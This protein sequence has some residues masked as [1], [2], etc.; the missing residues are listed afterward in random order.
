[1][2][3]IALLWAALLCTQANAADFDLARAARAC[4]AGE[5]KP[6][7]DPRISAAI[8]L[9]QEQHH[10]FGGQVIDRRGGIVR[11]GFHEAEFD[12]LKTEST[13]TWQRVAQFWASLEEDLPSTFRSP[14]GNMV[15]RRLM[16][17]RM[18]GLGGSNGLAQLGPGELDAVQSAM[19]RSALVD[20]PWSAAFISYLMKA[21][22]FAK[23]EFEFSDSHVD[24]VDQAFAA[25]AAEMQDAPTDAAYRACDATRTR[26]RA[27]DLICHTRGGSSAI[28]S[29]ATLLQGLELRRAAARPGEIPMHCDLVTTADAGGNSKLEAIGGNVFQSVTL[30]EMT[31]NA[32]KTL[33]ARYLQ[34][35]TAHQCNAGERCD[36][37]LSRKPWVVLLQFRN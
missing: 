4:G 34:G 35:P 17:E 9:A 7:R 18:A 27:G 23:R 12:R 32:Q 21:S 19:L 15:S 2:K 37:N 24:Y 28:D 31:L 22:G 3:W 16:M 36:R 11:V 14:N 8:A 29:Y 25:S 20:H 5:A 30:R 6:T 26:P 10:L 13:P 1:M 33:G